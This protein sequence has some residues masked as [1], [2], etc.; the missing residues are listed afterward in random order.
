LLGRTGGTHI[1]PCLCLSKFS[2][3]WS[4]SAL[5]WIMDLDTRSWLYRR[6]DVLSLTDKVIVYNPM[7]Q[8][9]NGAVTSFLLI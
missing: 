4:G 5:E 1:S 3:C 8:A 2:M 7:L 6:L 9:K